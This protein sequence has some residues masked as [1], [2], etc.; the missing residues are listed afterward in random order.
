[1]LA[2]AALTP[3]MLTRAVLTPRLP[4]LARRSGFLL[5]LSVALGVVGFG[6]P[7][8]VPPTPTQ[9]TGHSQDAVWLISAVVVLVLAMVLAALLDGSVDIKAIALLGVWRPW[10]LPCARWGREPPGWNRCSS[11]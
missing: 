3:A 6:W 5:G 1:M 8:L 2:R 4:G 9:G 10:G 7:F 11:S